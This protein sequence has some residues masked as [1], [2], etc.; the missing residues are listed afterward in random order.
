MSYQPV[1]AGNQPNSSVGIQ[2]NF[3]AG[4]CKK[5]A[6]S[7]EQY[8]LIPI[9]SFSSKDPQN[10]NATAFEVKEPKS[11]VYVSPCSSD[12]IKKHDE[13]TIREAKGKSP[14]ELYTGVR[15]LSDDFEEF[16]YNSTNCTACPF[17]NAISLN[18]KIDGKSSYVDPSQYPNDLDMSA[19]EDITYSDDK[20]DV[21]AEADFSNLETYITINPIPTTRVHKD[22]PV[23][24]IIGNLSSA[25]KTRSMT[26]MAKEQGG[27]TQINNNDFHTCMFT[28]FLSQEEP[29]RVHQALKDPSLIE[30][31]QEEL[32]QFKM[33]KENLMGR[34]MRIFYWIL[35]S[36]PTW[37]FDIDTLTQS[38]SYQPVVA[39]NQPNSSVGFQAN[40]SAGTSKKEAESVEQ[41]VLLPIW[42]FSSKY[43]Q[44]TNA[45][46]FEV[47]EPKSEVYVSPCSSDKIKK[48][49]EQTIR[50]AKGKS[51]V[52]LYTGVRDLSDDF[53]EFSDNSTNGVNAASTPVTAVG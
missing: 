11:E 40:F 26:R 12:K 22:H 10:I 24:Q 20:E 45:A 21:G 25:P 35:W 27:L 33:Q 30:A 29:K 15:D 47:K 41:Y 13:Q 23:T 5:E 7:V 37:L 43:P 31:M 32:L 19:L 49:D 4:T 36:G 39:G 50:E 2:A 46:A 53:E 8:V 16:F 52:E 42:S 34:L 1:V 6:E 3:S 38:M 44:N 18:F 9:W 17:N 28:C 14:V 51:P 48:H